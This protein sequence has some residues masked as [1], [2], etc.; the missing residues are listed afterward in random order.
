MSVNETVTTPPPSASSPAT[1]PASAASCRGRTAIFAYDIAA[2]VVLLV[3][4]GLYARHPE[5]FR[6]PD[7]RVVM[8]IRAAW[9]GALGGVVIGLKGIYDHSCTRGDW[10]DSFTLWHIGRP[11]SG[12]LAGL[13][14]LLLL[15]AANG[16][17]GGSLS[18]PTV[19]AIAF[20]FGTQERRFF[21]FLSEVAG[22]VVRVPGEDQPAGLKGGTIQ[23][24]QA[25]GG[26]IVL[27]TGRGFAQGAKV[28]IG[29]NPLENVVVGKDGTSIVGNVPASVAGA[30][31]VTIVNP[32][33][34]RV[35]LPDKF[36]YPA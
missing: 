4:G 31:D 23:P 28:T 2:V 11:V 13:I 21:N 10:D 36:T 25:R 27:I 5:H 1:K 16:G 12:G 8:A 7:D 30:V 18:E 24:S 19:Y 26:A 35:I 33:G 3:V 9:F 34:E 15:L 20:I 14:T 6:F 32:G 17:N 29:A 22:L